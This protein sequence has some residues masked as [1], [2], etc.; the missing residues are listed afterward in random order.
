MVG[1]FAPKQRHYVGVLDT[2]PHSRVKGCFLVSSDLRIV[3]DCFS[4]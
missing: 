4:F 1:D 2:T 3:C